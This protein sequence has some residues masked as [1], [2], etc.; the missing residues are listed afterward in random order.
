MPIV[1]GTWLVSLLDGTS[2]MHPLTIDVEQ[3]DKA[4]EEVEDPMY[5]QWLV[6][7][8]QVLSYLPPSMTKEILVQVASFGACFRSLEDHDKNLLISIEV[9]NFTTS[10]STF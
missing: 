10:F 4:K 3:Q 1:Q 6:H 5:A 8:Q 2:N 7:D 9:T